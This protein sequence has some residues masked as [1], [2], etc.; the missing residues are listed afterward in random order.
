M[1][2]I[3]TSHL[4]F[5]MLSYVLFVVCLAHARR[6]GP[7]RRERVAILLAGTVYGVL[8]ELLTIYQ[9]QAYRYGAFLVMFN[10]EVPLVIGVGWGM[11]LYAAMAV[12]DA[13][14]LS[15][16]AW[17][18]TVG[19][20]GLAIDSTMDVMA[21]RT[22]MWRWYQ[23]DALEGGFLTP[24]QDWYGVAYGNY[25]AWFVVL[26]SAATFFRLLLASTS[27]FSG[28]LLRCGAAIV[29][30]LAVLAGLDQLYVRF[31]NH[32]WWPIAVEVLL[33]SATI[34]TSWLRRDGTPRDPS[35]LEGPPAV[36]VPM[37]FHLL[38]LGLMVAGLVA[39]SV[40]PGEAMRD[41]FPQQAVVL[42]PLSAG[43]LIATLLVH[44]LAARSASSRRSGDAMAAT[45]RA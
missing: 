12:A 27:S 32:Q 4:L 18:A 42:L 21:V 23:G 33:A 37:F 31:A 9:L 35:A 11:I 2:S 1:A 20:W 19:L 7:R 10:D 45:S 5:E 39:P 28:L 30:S 15:L 36:A 22:E 17:A 6:Q 40:I 14:P 38:F 3:P 26:V 43:L 16:P 8:L 41:A 24:H 25:F 29:C 34:A 13:L 44:R